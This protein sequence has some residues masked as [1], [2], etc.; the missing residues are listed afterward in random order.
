MIQPDPKDPYQ[1]YFK[2]IVRSIEECGLADPPEKI[3]CEN[4][5]EFLAALNPNNALWGYNKISTKWIFRGH[6]DSSWSLLPS[7][8][9]EESIPVLKP[10]L[11]MAMQLRLDESLNRNYENHGMI[12]NQVTFEEYEKQIRA[13]M[14][15]I[16][17]IQE[18]AKL[19]NE[20]GYFI[21]DI[22]KTLDVNNISCAFDLNG[23]HF[24]NYATALAQHHGLPTR[25]LDWTRNPKI[26]AYFACEKPPS[27]DSDSICV[28]ALYTDTNYSIES[29]EALGNIKQFSVT[30]D[31][32]PFLHAQD[33]LFTYINSPPCDGIEYYYAWP[34]IHE[35]LSN[36]Y[37]DQYGDS[38]RTIYLP[39]KYRQELLEKLA[40]EG[41]TEITLKP[42]FN[43][44][45][46]HLLWAAENELL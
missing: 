15:E 9:R 19:A 27:L 16:L 35:C 24:P 10:F 5:D 12:Q 13:T 30:R 31:Q 33:G 7:S 34:D 38:I 40:R 46:E 11:D 22:E 4:T 37:R 26:A 41:V 21:K 23:V 3:F 44:I 8:W 28:H 18:F 29:S 14:A 42:G 1:W 45:S 43:S 20:N 25:I 36:R 39:E 32:F 6:Y 17:M 2:D